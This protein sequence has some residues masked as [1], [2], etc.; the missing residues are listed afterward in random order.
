MNLPHDWVLMLSGGTLL[1]RNGSGTWFEV[2]ADRVF[3][4]TADPYHWWQ[5]QGLLKRRVTDWVD[6]FGGVRFNHLETRLSYSDST[7]DDY[8][9]KTYTPL[10]GVQINRDFCGGSLMLRLSASA[11]TGGTMKYDFWDPA[12][13]SEWGDFNIHDTTFKE[14]LASYNR[15]LHHDKTVGAFVKWSS[16]DVQ[17]QKENL[18]GFST[19]PVSWDIGLH[20]WTV[21]GTLCW[22]F[23]S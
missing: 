15:R 18:S 12:G 1:P 14:V 23:G 20:P 5:A 13:K 2:P 10:I 6:I 16:F 7:R 22:R 19:V 9:L 8:E 21:G 11:L 4:F 17:S 3:D